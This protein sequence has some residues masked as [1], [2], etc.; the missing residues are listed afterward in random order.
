MENQRPLILVSNDD[1]ITAKGISEL[2]KF[3]RPLGEIVV[4]APDSPRSGSGCALTVTEPVHFQQVRRDVGLTVYKCSGTPTDCIKLARNTV[5]DREPSLVVGG[6]NHGDNSAT[7]V[8]YSGTMAVVIE[9]CLNGIP[10]I[11]FS[12]S[13]HAMDADFD[14][15]GPYVRQIA[16][17]VLEKGLPPLTCLNV[18]FPNVKEIKG[19]RVCQQAKGQWSKEWESCPRKTDTNYYWLTG[20]FTDHDPDNET[21]DRWALAH[22][23]AAITPTTV[24]VTAY[25]FM[26]ELG[27]WFN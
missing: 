26:E 12:L 17:T 1:G 5:L 6:I 18:N 22:G 10:S 14:A 15:M 23:Y 24:D 13:D 27:N 25:H 11:G 8:H 9:G 7:N 16:A 3:L 19:I 4:M 21:S 2:I 20:E